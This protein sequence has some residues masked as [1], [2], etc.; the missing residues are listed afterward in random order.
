M[1]IKLSVSVDEEILQ[2]ID[3]LVEAKIFRNRSHAFDFI[4][5]KEAKNG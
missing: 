2:R 5:F 3:K 1:K 4:I